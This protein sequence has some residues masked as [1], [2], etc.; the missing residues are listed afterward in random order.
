MKDQEIVAI[1]EFLASMPEPADTAELRQT[2]D[3]LGTVFPTATDV[4][5]ESVTANGVPAEWASTPGAAR[6]R[7]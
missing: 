6:D 7:V 4:T 5:L 3:N 2:Y 1:R